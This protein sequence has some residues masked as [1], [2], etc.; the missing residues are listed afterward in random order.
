[1]IYVH[2]GSGCSALCIEGNDNTLGPG[3]HASVTVAG[4]DVGEEGSDP[5]RLSEPL[6]RRYGNAHDLQLDSLPRHLGL[7]RSLRHAH[8]PSPRRFRQSD[9][10]HCCVSSE[11]E[12]NN[13]RNGRRQR[14]PPS[15]HRRSAWIV[16]VLPGRARCGRE[17]RHP[18]GCAASRGTAGSLQRERRCESGPSAT[19]LHRPVRCLRELAEPRGYGDLEQRCRLR[20]PDRTSLHTR[21]ADDPT[22]RHVGL[23]ALVARLRSGGHTECERLEL[24]LSDLLTS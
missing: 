13:L 2:S 24:D 6:G 19:E 9:R 4:L 12:R 16:R 11:L 3:L 17:F 5:A 18:R 20:G 15:G 10:R 21:G 14:T 1:M 22:G 23:P 8:P 7:V